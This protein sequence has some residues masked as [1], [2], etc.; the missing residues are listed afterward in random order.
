MSRSG[1]IPVRTPTGLY[2]GT[3]PVFEYV[4]PRVQAVID[5]IVKGLYFHN[6]RRRLPAHAVVADFILRQAGVDGV[7]PPVQ[8]DLQAA[9]CTL[10]L[11]KVG[12]GSV[13]SYRF[14]ES[15]VQPGRSRWFLMFFNRTLFD[16]CTGPNQP[17]SC[18]GG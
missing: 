9:I 7:A 2:V 14:F 18:G 6:L 5:K 16:T 8:T 3:Q 12:D 11:R 15:D 1:R 17:V 4:R 13:F 10:P